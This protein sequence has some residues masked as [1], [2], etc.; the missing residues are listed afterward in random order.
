MVGR[1]LIGCFPVRVDSGFVLYH[2]R[3]LSGVLCVPAPQFNAVEKVA[4]DGNDDVV[5]VLLRLSSP[6]E[7][8]SGAYCTVHK[9]ALANG[10]AHVDVILL[11][12][13]FAIALLFYK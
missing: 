8:T 12:H 5:V 13:V 4:V 7:T 3:E 2:D 11:R 9:I 1:N 10:I 6:L